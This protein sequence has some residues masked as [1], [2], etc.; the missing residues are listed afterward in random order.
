VQLSEQ[1][2]H[3]VLRHRVVAELRECPVPD[4]LD[5]VL[6]VHQ[7]DHEV[8]RRG[9][10]VEA[11]GSKILEHVPGLAAVLVTVDLRVGTQQRRQLRDPVPGRAEELLRH[12]LRAARTRGSAAAS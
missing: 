8:R 10:A 6:A 9:E 5:G 4:R 7:P 12:L 1:L 3:L 11:L 2:D